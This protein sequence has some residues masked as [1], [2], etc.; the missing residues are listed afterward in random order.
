MSVHRFLPLLVV[1]LTSLRTYAYD[2]QSGDLYYNITST[3]TV[4]VTSQKRYYD[5]T[6]YDGLASATIPE[7]VTHKN[8]TYS[9]TSIGD[10]AFSGCYSLTSITIPNSVTSIGDGAFYGCSSLTSINLPNSVTSIRDGAFAWCSSLTAMVVESGNTTYDSREN[11]NAIIETATN[12][13]IAGCQST[14]IPN[15]VAS[16]GESAFYG[17]SALNSITIPNSV[18]SIGEWA[19]AECSSLTSINLPNSV[20]SIGEWAFAECSSLTSIILPNSVTN[21]GESAFGG[22]YSLTSIILPNSVTSIGRYAFYGCYSLTSIILPNS[23]TSIGEWA[24]AWCSALTSITIPNSVKT[25]GKYAFSNV[26]NIVYHGKTKGSPRGAKSVNGYIDGYLVYGDNTKTKLLAC[27]AAARGE[28]TIP[29]SVKSIGDYAFQDCR[30]LT[31]ITIPNSVKQIGSCPFSGC[32]QLKDIY[33]YATTPP[34]C[35]YSFGDIDNNCRIH[36]PKGTL[37]SYRVASG[38]CVFNYFCEISEE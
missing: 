20:T 31:S 5:N 9:V 37:D 28:I 23:V 11:C 21:I 12:T 2:F 26:P 14:I 3:N 16:I 17:C 7:T 15:S 35:Y 25:I 10:G 30:S 8:K 33:C 38:W 22:C 1:L 34:K 24:F 29:N 36:V 18:T 32:N 27:S 4:E 19:F 13:L 6:N